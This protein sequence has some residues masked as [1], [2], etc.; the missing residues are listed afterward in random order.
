MKS[1]PGRLRSSFGMPFEVWF[2]RSSASS[3]SRLVMSVMGSR[4]RG[5]PGV[6]H[7]R[8]GMASYARRGDVHL[9]GLNS[10]GEFTKRK[11]ILWGDF[12][13]VTGP[14]PAHAGFSKVSWGDE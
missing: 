1:G 2:S 9:W 5:E 11:E 3:P 10:K 4:L 13:R 7:V 8:S 14:D 6:V 12:L